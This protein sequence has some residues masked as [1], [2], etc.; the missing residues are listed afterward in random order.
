MMSPEDDAPMSFRRALR[1]PEF[2][3]LLVAAITSGCGVSGWIVVPATMTGLL[4]S[5]L[6]K[7]GPLYVQAKAAGVTPAFWATVLASIGNAAVAA[8]AAF[9][10]GRATWWLWGL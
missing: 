5:S 8:I 10:L 9:V 3:L 4:I 1:S 6:P 7:Y 2:W